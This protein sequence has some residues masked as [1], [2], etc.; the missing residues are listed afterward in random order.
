[1]ELKNIIAQNIIELRKRDKLT[2]AE[3]AEKLNYTDKAISKWER[4]ESI[5]SVEILKQIADMFG[6][7]VDFLLKEGSFDDKQ[8]MVIHREGIKNKITI[9]ALMVTIVWFIATL[10]YVYVQINLKIN[11][12]VLFVWAV[13]TSCLVLA[14]CNFKWGKRIY[15]LYISSLLT[16]SMLTSLYLTFLN[17]QI[18]LVFIVGIPLQILAI[19]WQGLTPKPKKI[20][21]IHKKND[22]NSPTDNNT[23]TANLTNENNPN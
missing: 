1:M 6:V 8:D 19:L 21:I 13:P 11:A 12:W 4:G 20:K 16:W 3:L 18:W 17:Y 5:P 14:V 10:I 2:Q 15:G 22:E 9:T 23:P 7:T